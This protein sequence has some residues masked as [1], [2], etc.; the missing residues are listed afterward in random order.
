MTPPSAE[1][2]FTRRSARRRRALAPPGA[3]AARQ[4]GSS[5]E[6]YR[7]GPG[8]PPREYQFRPGQSGNPNGGNGKSRSRSKLLRDLKAVFERALNEK[9]K[10]GERA[11]IMTKFEAGCKELA[12]QFAEG[13]HRARR[14]VL[15]Y[16]PKLGIDLTAD[17]GD[18]RYVD[19]NSEV[20]LRQ[21]LLDR[22]IPTRLLPPIDAAG[23]EP[24]PDPP[25]PP[26]AEEREKAQ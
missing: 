22:G 4:N 8:H 21:A 7:V 5:G 1:G 2:A 19:E 13:D 15:A 6:E 18:R 26:N 11:E 14:D 16:A 3:I 20:E 12:T 25:L 23:L 24:P 17:R 9:V 10:R